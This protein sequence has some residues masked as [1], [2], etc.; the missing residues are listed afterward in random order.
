MAILTFLSSMQSVMI[1]PNW[2]QLSYAIFVAVKYTYITILCSL[3]VKNPGVM[4]QPK[5]VSY[6]EDTL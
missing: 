1:R 6:L 4:S 3:V 5:S 2:P